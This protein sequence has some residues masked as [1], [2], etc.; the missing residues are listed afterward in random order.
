MGVA[1]VNR[2]RILDFGFSIFDWRVKQRYAS[3]AL[4]CISGF[5]PHLE[6]IAVEPSMTKRPRGLVP[7]GAQHVNAELV[8]EHASVQPGGRTRVGVRFKIEEG[9]HIY[10]Q[11]P[12]DAGLPTTVSWSAP[13]GATVEPLRWPKPRQFL[14]PGD[15]R[16]FGYTGTVLLSSQ[17][18]WASGNA[19]GASI[20]IQARVEWLAC[21]E[22]CVPGSAQLELMLPISASA[23]GP[24]TSAHL[25]EKTP[26][27]R[28]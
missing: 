26:R 3:L 14:D 8:A 11:D 16:T 1:I 2:G 6:A 7:P 10:A 18:A 19:A 5:I 13:Q 25:F 23:P 4:L 22:V 20:P 28:R 27:S 12:G 21:K 15:I 24:S 9:W 17:L